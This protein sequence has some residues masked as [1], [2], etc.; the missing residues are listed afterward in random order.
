MINGFKHFLIFIYLL[1]KLYQTEPYICNLDWKVWTQ[2]IL[3]IPKED[4]LISGLLCISLLVWGFMQMSAYTGISQLLVHLTGV[5]GYLNSYYQ[6]L[7][8]WATT[9]PSWFALNER[10]QQTT[11]WHILAD[12]MSRWKLLQCWISIKVNT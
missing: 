12:N 10:C 11:I 3:V 2:R 6:F 4:F 1:T 7:R 8:K 5:P 9:C